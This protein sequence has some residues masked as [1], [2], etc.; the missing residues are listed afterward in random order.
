MSPQA[1][2]LPVNKPQQPQDG[3]KSSA[4]ANPL[5]WAPLHLKLST[6]LPA[7]QHSG[8]KT[9]LCLRTFALAVSSACTPSTPTY[10]HGSFSP[11]Y[12]GLCSHIP[13]SD[14]L[15]QPSWLQWHHCHVSFLCLD[16][17][18]FIS[19][20]TAPQHNIYLFI[21]LSSMCLNRL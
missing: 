21:C 15:A 9:C 2:H 4:W 6:P 14:C 11:L 7:F 8:L 5:P 1:W 18:F 3:L 20:L 19:P 12:S 16:L 10:L 17:F 13:S